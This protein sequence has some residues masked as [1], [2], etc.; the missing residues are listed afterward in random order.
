MDAGRY[1]VSFVRQVFGGRPVQVTATARWGGGV[2]Q[3]LA[4]TLEF[5]G[6]NGF[7]V[8]IDAFV[9]LLEREDRA[10]EREDRAASLDAG[11]DPRPRPIVI[12]RLR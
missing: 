7:R 9:D 12:A 4:A 11:H 10:A 8:Q 1:P 6:E 5:P 2:D 3:T